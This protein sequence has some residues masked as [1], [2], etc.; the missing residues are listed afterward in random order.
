MFFLKRLQCIPKIPEK[1]FEP[2][3]PKRLYYSLRAHQNPSFPKIIRSFH[4]HR[5]RGYLRLPASRAL[6][7]QL[8]GRLHLCY[9]VSSLSLSRS[10]ARWK[11]AGSQ[12]ASICKPNNKYALSLSHSRVP[13]LPRSPIGRAVDEGA[14]ASSACAVAAAAGRW[15]A[16]PRPHSRALNLRAL[17]LLP[18]TYLYFFK[19]LSLLAF[20]SIGLWRDLCARDSENREDGEFSELASGCMLMSDQ[21]GCFYLVM[22]LWKV[23]GVF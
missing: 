17:P 19:W 10:L 16:P 5:Q 9:A 12:Q 6:H 1:I 3:K 11:F 22:E 13:R 21:S 8:T 7:L 15:T 14:V 4:H 23:E 2:R 18:S 20:F